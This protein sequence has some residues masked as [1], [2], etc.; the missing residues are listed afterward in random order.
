MEGIELIKIVDKKKTFV[1]SKGKEVPSYRYCVC[2]N[3]KTIP[4]KPIFDDG[5]LQLDLLSKVVYKD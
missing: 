1:N 5:Y 3:G 4:V 2:Y